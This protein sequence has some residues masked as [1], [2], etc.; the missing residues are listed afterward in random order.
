MRMSSV[1]PSKQPCLFLIMGTPLTTTLAI[2]L[3]E[4]LTSEHIL[5]TQGEIGGHEKEESWSKSIRLGM[6]F[7]FAFEQFRML[8]QLFTSVS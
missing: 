2:F 6:F 3:L 4:G 7:F 5:S 8:S 1:Y